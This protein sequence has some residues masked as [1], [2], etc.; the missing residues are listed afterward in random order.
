MTDLADALGMS[1]AFG[2]HSNLGRQPIA[3]RA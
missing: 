3:Q 2:L 1:A